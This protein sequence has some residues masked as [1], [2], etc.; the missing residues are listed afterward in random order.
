MTDPLEQILRHAK[1]D[2]DD[3][4][5]V[6]QLRREDEDS[7]D[8]VIIGAD[9]EPLTFW[10]PAE[11][12]GADAARDSEGNML[13]VMASTPPGVRPA[14]LLAIPCSPSGS[15]VL[16]MVAMVDKSGH[17]Q[18]GVAGDKTKQPPAGLRADMLRSLL[19]HVA[20]R[21]GDSYSTVRVPA[22]SGVLT[23][24]LVDWE[25]RPLLCWLPSVDDESRRAL[26]AVA[27]GA[28]DGFVA[29][30]VTH[31]LHPTHSDDEL[32]KLLA[33]RDNE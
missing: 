21:R 5:W 7:W 13:M 10:A 25:S 33:S 26:Y 30:S 20:Q 4:L 3:R 11:P 19:D 27:A 24:V 1:R 14:G 16:R 31:D 8:T 28:S 2:E 17:T 23:T 9:D 32:A 12:A 29:V 22:V 6:A 15:P 18:I